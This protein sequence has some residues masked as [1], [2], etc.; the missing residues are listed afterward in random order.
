[1]ANGSSPGN[2][3]PRIPPWLRLTPPLALL[4]ALVSAVGLF[5]PDFYR[6]PLAW[7]IQAV[8]Q[9]F[10]DLV[11]VLPVLVASAVLAARGSTRG[12]LVCLGALSYLVYTFAIYAFAVP[13]NRLFL[14]YVAMLGG[15]LWALVGGMAST[16]WAG[17]KARFRP[18]APVRA[19][20]LFL[21]VPALLFYLLWLSEELPALLSGEIPANLAQLGV[22]TNPVHVLDL[23][24]MLPAMALA[25]VWLWQRRAVGIGLAVVLFVNMLMQDFAISSVMVFSMR[26]GLPASPVMIGVFAA[27]A[28]AT[29]GALVWHLREF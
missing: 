27:F 24:I 14:A 22:L 21:L 19:I 29:L 16:D 15:S 11:L 10:A 17:I 2:S 13:Y 18:D 3:A 25:G 23:A 6:G 1:M 28:A 4:L 12:R 9:D 7:S 26:A 5:V 8:A 20:S